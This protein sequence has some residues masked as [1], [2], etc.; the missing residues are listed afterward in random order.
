[1]I[2]VAVPALKRVTAAGRGLHRL[3]RTLNQDILIIFGALRYVHGMG[4]SNRQ[5]LT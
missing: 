5:G 1:M 3:F 2:R 4:A